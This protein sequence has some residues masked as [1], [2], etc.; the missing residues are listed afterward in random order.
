MVTLLNSPLFKE[1]LSLCDGRF[2][3]LRHASPK[4]R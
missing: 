2:R 3:A 4:A 1:W